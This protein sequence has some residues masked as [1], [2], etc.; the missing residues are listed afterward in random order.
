MLG[1]IDITPLGIPTPTSIVT[2]P[3]YTLVPAK[4]GMFGIFHVV[5]PFPATL[6]IPMEFCSPSKVIDSYNS[7]EIWISQCFQIKVCT[8][9]H[10]LD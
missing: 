3:M 1:D 9:S 7:S 2:N 5:I 4:L 10:R 6:S 8:L